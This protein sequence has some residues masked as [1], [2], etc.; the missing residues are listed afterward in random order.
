MEN[1]LNEKA[2]EY[3]QCTK[4]N[5]K[6][7]L[8]L[9]SLFSGFHFQRIISYI[10]FAN[11]VKEKITAKINNKLITFCNLENLRAIFR[12]SVSTSAACASVGQDQRRWN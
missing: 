3:G 2:Q 1:V 11:G 6:G 7:Q 12:H 4:H 10:I 5:L 9:D 8:T